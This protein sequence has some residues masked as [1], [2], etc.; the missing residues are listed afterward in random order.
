ML[1]VRKKIYAV[2]FLIIAFIGSSLGFAL[3]RYNRRFVMFKLIQGYGGGKR[4]KDLS[5]LHEVKKR[6]VRIE[7]AKGMVVPAWQADEMEEIVGFL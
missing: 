6:P 2:N 1:W 3:T 5:L 4:D 7:R